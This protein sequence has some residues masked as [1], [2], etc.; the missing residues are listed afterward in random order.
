MRILAGAFGLGAPNPV[1][2]VGLVTP[3]VGVF[4]E[5]D[6]FFPGTGNYVYE[7][8]F[9]LPF[10]GIVGQGGIFQGVKYPDGRWPT[11]AAI[12]P[13]VSYPLG[14]TAGYG[15]LQAGAFV[16]QPLLDGTDDN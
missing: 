3:S 12:A 4:H 7:P 16:Q 5:G 8:M 11:F 6:V 2:V 14:T 1:V 10:K 9:E 15:G 13:V